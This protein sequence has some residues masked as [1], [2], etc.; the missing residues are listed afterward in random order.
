[1]VSGGLIGAAFVAWF[2]IAF[3]Q[4]ARRRLASRDP[5]RRASCIGALT[6]IFAVASH[7]LV[8]FGLHI[9][10]NQVVFVGLIVVATLGERIEEK[11]LLR[12]KANLITC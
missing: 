3:F 4:L 9:T 11:P 7:S 8:D 1:M 6:G 2:G 10:V 5:F 12:G